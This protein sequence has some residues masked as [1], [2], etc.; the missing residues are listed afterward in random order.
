MMLFG[1][2]TFPGV[3]TKSTLGLDTLA[4]SGRAFDKVCGCHL[5]EIIQVF[6]QEGK[7]L[8]NSYDLSKEAHEA[9]CFY[10]RSY[11]RREY[12]MR[13]GL[14]TPTMR[15]AYSAINNAIREAVGREA[16]DKLRDILIED[17]G[18]GR[19]WGYSPAV[20]IISEAAYKRAKRVAKVNIARRLGLVG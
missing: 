18:K 19:G 13:E 9:V 20:Y 3:H 5:F 2:R 11:H 16:D 4:A 10:C 7:I 14:C 15:A 6:Y 12:I 8:R 1:V 17:I